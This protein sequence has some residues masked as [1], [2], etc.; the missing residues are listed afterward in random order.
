MVTELLDCSLTA[1]DVNVQAGDSQLLH[2]VDF[3][4]K[5]GELIAL[6]GPNGAGK[7]TLL[8][9]L[10]GLQKSV[11]G[12]VLLDRQPVAAYSS[13]QRARRVAYLPQ[14]RPMAW[15]NRVHDVVALGRFAHGVML[16]K[17]SVVDAAA[18]RQ[19]LQ[20]CDLNEFADRRTDTLS[21]GEMARVHCARVYAADAPLLIADEPTAGL[22]PLHQH[23]VLGLLRNYV[24]A[25]HGVL[26]V[27][28]DVNLALR[29]ADRL[30]WMRNGR[31][32]A[33]DPPANVSAARITEIYGVPA[34]IQDIEASGAAPGD[35]V[36]PGRF[37]QVIF[38]PP[39]SGDTQ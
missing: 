5:S 22:D 30:V 14:E 25:G 12:T 4:F 36:P 8:R 3:N 13:D 26:V 34:W 32:V 38:G 33:E 11:T 28:H 10:L 6:L 31:I 39:G 23:T 7:T 2:E 37:R 35:A 9:S 27:V 20:A 15:P 24:D 21:G 29:Y 17:L 18:V 19:A 16:G 1:T